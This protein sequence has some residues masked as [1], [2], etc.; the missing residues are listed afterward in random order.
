MKNISIDKIPLFGISNTT[1]IILGEVQPF[2]FET[3]KWTENEL[4]LLN[5]IIELLSQNTFSSALVAAIVKSPM[6]YQYMQVD[7]LEV[8]QK[9]MADEIAESFITRTKEGV[10]FIVDSLQTNGL[11]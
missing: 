11:I 1:S 9:N 5:D 2:K 7:I 6:M 4:S 10:K 3:K 8:L